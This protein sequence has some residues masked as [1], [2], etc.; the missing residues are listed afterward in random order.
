MSLQATT[1]ATTM[2][3]GG[4]LKHLALEEADYFTLKL[5]HAPWEETVAPAR[6]NLAL[7]LTVG[8]PGLPTQLTWPDGQTPAS[9]GCSST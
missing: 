8:D 9:A 2:T 5:L 1:A 7:A 6:A 4:M 3:V